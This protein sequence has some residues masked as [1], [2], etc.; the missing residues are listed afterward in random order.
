[1]KNISKIAVE[2]LAYNR[3]LQNKVSELPRSVRKALEKL[4]QK[5]VN[6]RDGGMH[7]SERTYVYMSWPETKKAV[8]DLASKEKQDFKVLWYGLNYIRSNLD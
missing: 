2:I 7:D 4:H 5:F 1:M 8:K 3:D 6:T